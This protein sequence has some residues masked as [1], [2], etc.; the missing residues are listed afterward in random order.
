MQYQR[1]PVHQEQDYSKVGDMKNKIQMVD[2][3]QVE[4]VGIMSG[5]MDD[6]EGLLEEL[7]AEEMER[8]EEGD[9][10]EEG[11]GLDFRLFGGLNF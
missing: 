3:D 10:A 9:E 5:F 6:L 2:D 11:T 8:M 1:Q 7:S 4:N